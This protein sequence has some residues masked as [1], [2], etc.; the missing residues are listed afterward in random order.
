MTTMMLRMTPR[1]KMRFY[2]TLK[3]CKCVDLFSM[4]LMPISVRSNPSVP[5]WKRLPLLDVLVNFIVHFK[6]LLL[7]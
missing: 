4:Q 6:T 1:K 5:E 3:C 2:F 7:P